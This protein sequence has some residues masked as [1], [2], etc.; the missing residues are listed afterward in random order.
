[1]T[2]VQLSEILP[3]GGKAAGIF[4]SVLSLAMD[5]HQINARLRVAAFKESSQSRYVRELSSD[6]CPPKYD[7]GCDWVGGICA[8]SRCAF[9]RKSDSSCPASITTRLVDIKY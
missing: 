6:A 7:I 9:A 3:N 1:M 5:R 4:S 2:Q 8:P